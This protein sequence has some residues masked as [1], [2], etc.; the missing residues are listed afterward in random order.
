MDKTSEST[1]INEAMNAVLN[2]QYSRAIELFICVKRENNPFD[3]TSL[4]Y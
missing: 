4:E 3:S 2:G 1:Y